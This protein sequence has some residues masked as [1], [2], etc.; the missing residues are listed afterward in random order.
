MSTK[1]ASN[2]Y[3][4]TNGSKHQGEKDARIGY[5]W[6]KDFSKGGLDNHFKKHGNQFGVKSKE[7]YASQSVHFANTINRKQYKS[8]I[9]Y[10][11]TTYKYDIKNA[12][13]AIITKDGYVISYHYIRKEFWYYK[14]K[15]KKVWIKI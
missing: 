4:K 7:E 1:G 10:N 6:A 13:L 15:G 12:I 5:A 3:G 8:L 2:R 14:K 11:G 9:D